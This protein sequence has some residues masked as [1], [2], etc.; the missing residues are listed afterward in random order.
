[1]TPSAAAVEDAPPAPP[2][3]PAKPFKPVAAAERIEALDVVR[4]FALLGIFLMNI[5]VF[6]RFFSDIFA[7]GIPPEAKGLDWAATFFV[8]YFVQGKFWTIFSTLFGMGFAVMLVRAE[9]AGR[10]F[11]QV[12]LRRIL[13]LA[14]FGAVHYIFIWDGDILFSY[15]VGAL[16][17]MLVLYARPRVYLLLIAACIGLGF[18]AKPFFGMAGGLAATGLVALYLR[19]EKRVRLRGI[20][21]PVFSLLLMGIGLLLGIAAVA[22]WVL[23][24]APTDPR[25]PTSV[26]GPLLFIAGWLSW[27][28]VDPPEKRSLRIAVSLY[29]FGGVV[30]TSFGLLQHFTPDPLVKLTEEAKKEAAQKAAAPTAAAQPV[31]ARPAASGVKVE[32]AE[33]PEKSKAE[34]AAAMKEER[35]RSRR[36]RDAEREKELQ[37]MKAGKWTDLV[38]LRADKFPEKAAGDFGFGVV[39]VGMFLIGMWFVRSGVMENTAQ[40]L[41]LFRR[42]A[43][44]GVPLGWG[45]SLLSAAIATSHVPGERHD[46][47]GIAGGLHMLANLPACVG[48]IALVVLMLHSRGAFARIRVLAPVGRMALTNY[49]MQSVICGFYFYGYGLGHFG[50]GRAA[51]LVFVLIIFGL[52]IV[53]SHWWLS[54]FRYGPMEW[55]W[56]GFTYRE[57][58]PLRIAAGPQAEAPR[59]A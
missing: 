47:W 45:L 9:K 25:M 23:P 27:K 46:G 34:R 11:V 38:Y 37:L 26:F 49:L 5:E 51:Q 53:F 30:A 55:L 54:R 4:G 1:M 20:A 29:V 43:L 58:P 35:D 56:R 3:P 33:K 24:N 2:P 13:G 28:Y 48:Y 41:P 12:Y 36:E 50:M 17:L 32:K 52:Q 19:S 22:L 8:N 42:L 6:N 31:P 18:L 44:V 14:V 10:P 21:L 39:L 40:H 7:R 57:V 59:A 16:M 15:S